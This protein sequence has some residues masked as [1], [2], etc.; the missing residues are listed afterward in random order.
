LNLKLAADFRHASKFICHLLAGA[1]GGK[2]HAPA[3]PYITHEVG[4]M[5]F[6][7]I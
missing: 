2:P 4:A 7:S 3:S 6:A 1:D 5:Q